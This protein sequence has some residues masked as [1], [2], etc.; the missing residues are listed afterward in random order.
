LQS[1]LLSTS[2]NETSSRER[3]RDGTKK[4][5]KTER[6]KGER[7]GRIQG[8]DRERPERRKIRGKKRR[9][10]RNRE[11]EAL[12]AQETITSRFRLQQHAQPSLLSPAF[13]NFINPLL[14]CTAGSLV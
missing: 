9:K 7:R 4:K 12:I 3:E 10:N 8:T 1:S 13:A 5:E 11:R 6:T 14:L 2:N